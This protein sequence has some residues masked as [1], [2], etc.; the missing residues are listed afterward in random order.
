MKGPKTEVSINLRQSISNIFDTPLPHHLPPSFFRSSVNI[1]T[2]QHLDISTSRHHNHIMGPSQALNFPI[3][4]GLHLVKV[5]YGSGFS[6]R[7]DKQHQHHYQHSDGAIKQLHH[8]SC[9]RRTTRKIPSVYSVVISKRYP[10]VNIQVGLSSF[11]ARTIPWV[12]NHLSARSS[13][14]ASHRDA[15][16]HGFHIVLFIIRTI[17]EWVMGLRV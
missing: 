13:D 4:I 1:S 15:R 14:C 3:G 5:G 10:L 6:F 9:I 2:S 12:V 17:R 8:Q 16:R 7:F 11:S